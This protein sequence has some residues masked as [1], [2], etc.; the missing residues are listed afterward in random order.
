MPVFMES[1]AA[2]S[3]N[4][5]RLGIVAGFVTCLAYPLIVFVPLPML[6]SAA[7]AACFG[8]RLPWLAMA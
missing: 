5:A 4:A 3:V 6:A 8:P 1:A 2:S 7:I